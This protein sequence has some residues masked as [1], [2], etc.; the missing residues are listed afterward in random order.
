[1]FKN[2]TFFIYSALVFLFFYASLRLGLFYYNIDL[3]TDIPTS[4]I[5]KSFF[6]GARFDLLIISYIFL[7]IILGLFFF[8]GLGYR[9]FIVIWLSIFFAITSFLGV[10][11][12][13]F[14]HEFHLRL[15]S[16][17]FE[18]IKEDPKTVFNMI[19]NTETFPVVRYLIL[20]V[21]YILI[22]IFIIRFVSK[23]TQPLRTHYAK[24]FTA[25]FVVLL[26]FVFFSRGTLRSGPP[27]RWGDAYTTNHLFTNQLG[28]N[29]SYTLLKAAMNNKG[30]S[31]QKWLTKY[32]KTKALETTKK[33]LKNGN[34][35]IKGELPILRN[36]A[37]ANKYQGNVKNV[38]V[39]IMESF[40]GMYVGA[41]GHNDEEITP[42]FDEIT[43]D[44][45][46]FTRFFS[47]GTHTHQGMFATIG[48]FPNLP[49]YEYLM[50]REEATQ[51][52][53]SLP[54]VL[55]NKITN[56]AYVYNGDFSWD[57]QQGFFATQGMNNFIG[58]FDYKNPKFIDPTW[59]VSDGDMFDRAIIEL[60]KL[61][62]KKEPFYAVLQT[63]SNHIPFKL[64]DPLPV[65]KALNSKGEYSERLTAMRYADWA[66]GEFYKSI[67]NK[68]YFKDT[69]FIFLGD[70]GFGNNTQITDMDLSRFYIPMLIVA[71]KIQDAFGKTNNTV[72][73]QVD[74]IPTVLGLLKD[75]F[76]SQ[77][78]GRNLLSLNTS[79]KGFAIIK[80]S[81]SSPTIAIIEGDEIAVFPENAT[82]TLWKYNLS[83][84]SS[85]KIT[86]KK[87][88]EAKK[89][90]IYS[91]IQTA[92][93]A[94][95][96]HKVGLKAGTKI[97][98][99][100]KN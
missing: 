60:D 66:V 75:K 6:T 97:N 10:I 58:R 91:Y 42:Y 23:K 93:Q 34:E 81:G 11:E 92:M 48:G 79:D 45:L 21:T 84:K 5:L 85:K 51:K 64:P 28:L 16:M 77:S 52:F 62:S 3:A 100:V 24:H 22:F 12:L 38:V 44:G 70:H 78:W 95:I 96:S 41:L 19:I 74:V 7:P 29:G 55:N 57:N 8:R 50:Q 71:P 26:I 15:N 33:M 1:M 67:K 88:K 56:N 65:K 32:N 99:K 4:E 9:K 86:N 36:I 17:V 59:G 13:E 82:S 39:I 53:S 54:V 35:Y 73:T 98:I 49:G 40:S 14:Y 90:R 69:A 27:L 72:G 20:S 89:V 30:K 25:T 18:Y 76:I 31:N 63:L 83:D 47:N 80:P 2:L 43:K 61:N 94:L 37:Q 87:D 46:L 68:P